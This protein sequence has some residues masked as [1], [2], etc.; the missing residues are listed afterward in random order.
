MAEPP[1][2]GSFA[3]LADAIDAAAGQLAE[4]PA[5]VEAGRRV[6]FAEW[7]GAADGV[8]A[9]LVERG[10]RP[11]DVVAIMLPPS[12][13][14]AVAFAAI[15][16]M[17]AVAT[18][19]N[20]RLGR[21][22]VTAIAER[23]RPVLAVVPRGGPPAGLP[24]GLATLDP[25]ELAAAGAGPPLGDCRHHGSPADPAVIV[26]TSGTTGL[27]K[28]AWFHHDNLRAAVT[29]A[30]VMTAPF[31][32]RLV[33]TPFAHAGYMVKLWE[34]LAWATTVVISPT[35]WRA[36]D[37][38]RLMIDER[39]TVAGGAPAQWEK[40]LEQ[41]GLDRA[42][43]GALR[44]GVAATA[45]APP[46]LVARV[47][48]RC[49]CPLVVRYAM[50]ESPSIT[51]TEPGDR[52][53]VLYRTV[54]RPQAGIEVA[55]RDE[56]GA[57][58]PDGTVGRIHVRGGCVMRGYWQEPEL[59]AEVLN[60]EGWLRSS[61]LGH[62]DPDGN[63]VLAGRMGDMYIRGGYNVHPLQVENV[64]TEHPAVA[65]AAVV[66]APAP[67]LGEIGVAYV[68]VAP[69]A[70]PPTLDELRAWCQERLADYKAPDRLELVEAL[71]FTSMMKVDKL[72][73][74]AVT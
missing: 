42:D 12:I 67:V 37:M 66:G 3:T 58:V 51:G 70:E 29:T 73:L 18:G 33:S 34:Q 19:C 15:A 49:G 44:L 31:D 63:L 65:Q 22:E 10:V 6:T 7:L 26:W 28:G 40:L 36:A 21:R 1:L 11:G 72:A 13:D 9:A 45:P 69:G 38:L 17:G 4:V 64:L 41:P 23:C 55:I 46:E 71:P 30:G 53:E 57:P 2:R 24:P 68:V 8:A 25:D 61:D 32:R 27:P 62:M 48:E 59:T 43:L 52:P 39:I 16:R 14:Y 35:P 50:T 56:Q 5:Y 20:V 60:P 47:V 74:R 54:G